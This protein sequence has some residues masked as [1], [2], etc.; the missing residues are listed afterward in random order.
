[1]QS[2]RLT[3]KPTCGIILALITKH[4]MR[5]IAER[6]ERSE[7]SDRSEKFEISD[8]SERSE[9]SVTLVVLRAQLLHPALG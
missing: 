5:F 6:S 4:C 8:Q 3:F 1:M 2:L 7:I 9:I